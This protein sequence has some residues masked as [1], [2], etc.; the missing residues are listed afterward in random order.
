MSGQPCFNGSLRGLCEGASPVYRPGWEHASAHELCTGYCIMRSLARTHRH[1][2][3]VLHVNFAHR[4][5]SPRDPDLS[6]RDAESKPHVTL[7]V[8]LIHLPHLP[9]CLA[10]SHC[11]SQLLQI[12]YKPLH[13]D[14]E[15]S[16][17]C[18]PI[19][20]FSNRG[21]PSRHL[22]ALRTDSPPLE[23][24]V[25][26]S[27]A[28]H[29]ALIRLGVSDFDYP[30]SIAFS[31]RGPFPSDGQDKGRRHADTPTRRTEG[32]SPAGSPLESGTLLVSAC[33]FA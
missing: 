9:I 2:Q 5:D 1:S 27:S 25:C 17:R 16:F 12:L 13:T 10:S 3:D 6:L 11:T 30:S 32:R 28:R 15:T 19:A 22:A 23:Y 4:S 24:H 29:L 14:T 18:G 20:T 26:T 8:P 7:D 33:P 31:G 21:P